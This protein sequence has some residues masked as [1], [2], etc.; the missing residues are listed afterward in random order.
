LADVQKNLGNT[1]FKTTIRILEDSTEE[2]NKPFIIDFRLLNS[3][4]ALFEYEPFSFSQDKP[5]SLVEHKIKKIKEYAIEL[6]NILNE[7][8][9]DKE[10]PKNIFAYER[11]ESVVKDAL[12]KLFL[13]EN[14]EINK[15]NKN[16]EDGFAFAIEKLRESCDISDKNFV[17]HLTVLNEQKT[18]KLK[19]LNIFLENK[20]IGAFLEE[21]GKKI[22]E[23]K[24]SKQGT[25]SNPPTDVS[26][27]NSSG[28]S[29]GSSA[30][31]PLPS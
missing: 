10:F 3:Q 9:L 13:D 28:K 29:I 21:A 26:P 15:F 14:G 2:K 27:T 7:K 17:K 20:G 4:D 19:M 6:Q 30:N 24:L 8:T 25:E 23:E 11:N 31:S 5:F 16:I 22:K 12:K 1:G 18:E